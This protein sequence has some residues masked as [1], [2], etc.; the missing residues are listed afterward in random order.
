MRKDQ[1]K[2]NCSNKVLNKHNNSRSNFENTYFDKNLTVKNK[3]VK[4]PQF[5][6]TRKTPFN[7]NK[8]KVI[9]ADDSITKALRSDE[10][11]TRERS[12]TVMKH[13]GCSVNP[14]LQ[15]SIVKLMLILCLVKM[16]NS[17]KQGNCKYF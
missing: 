14:T 16:E 13:I 17:K 9:V 4:T 2:T 1:P 8:K 7:T 10:L 11:S 12:V 3:S 15:I 5:K 6:V